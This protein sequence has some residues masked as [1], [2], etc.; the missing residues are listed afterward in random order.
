MLGKEA[1]KLRQATASATQSHT[2]PQPVTIAISTVTKA[3]Q[4]YQ[5][6]LAYQALYSNLFFC[7]F[8]SYL[9]TFSL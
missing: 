7:F 9:S 2:V 1:A 3:I 4:K 6:I 5:L 8:F